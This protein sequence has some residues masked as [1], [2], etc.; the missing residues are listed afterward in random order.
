MYKPFFV[1]S[2]IIPTNSKYLKFFN[3]QMS[4]KVNNWVSSPIN[5]DHTGGIYV[6]LSVHKWAWECVHFLKG[7]CSGDRCRSVHWVCDWYVYPYL[8]QLCCDCCQISMSLCIFH[9]NC[10]GSRSWTCVLCHELTHFHAFWKQ[11][12]VLVNIEDGLLKDA[13][14]RWKEYGQMSG[15]FWGNVV[16]HSYSYNVN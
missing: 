12:K 6:C 2:L 9:T 8:C 14:S 1:V 3:I 4:R 10:Q 13:Q 5:Q 15:C 11:R 7:V 16:L